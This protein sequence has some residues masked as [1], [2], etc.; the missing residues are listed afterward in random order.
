MLRLRRRR[1]IGS[2]TQIEWPEP[3]FVFISLLKKKHRYKK[4]TDEETFLVFEHKK[5]TSGPILFNSVDTLPDDSFVPSVDALW[6]VDT[7]V[8][9]VEHVYWPWHRHLL[10][11]MMMRRRRNCW[12]QLHSIRL[13]FYSWSNHPLIPI[14]IVLNLPIEWRWS[15]ASN[16]RNISRNLLLVS[17]TMRYSI[18]RTVVI[19]RD[20][21]SLLEHSNRF[22]RQ[23]CDSSSTRDSRKWRWR[24]HRRELT[25][26]SCSSPSTL[27]FKAFFNWVV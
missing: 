3:N 1:C 8:S 7:M 12:H 19:D 18:W 6:E 17:M 2:L 5:N 4:R 14:R 26:S 24:T 25:C 27:P 20:H 13:H 15:S 23:S 11:L 21:E 16:R 10:Q 22:Y 9:L